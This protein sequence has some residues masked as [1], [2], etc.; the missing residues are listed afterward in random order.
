MKQISTALTGL[1]C[2][3][4]SGAV[5]AQKKVDT[6]PVKDSAK[7]DAINMPSVLS[8][9]FANL[10]YS[11]TEFDSNGGDLTADGFGLSGSYLLPANLVPMLP[12]LYV[13]AGYSM[14]ETEKFSGGTVEITDYRLGVGY[15]LALSNVL[16]L[17]AEVDFL[18]QEGEGKGSFSGIEGDDDGF[19]VGALGRYA[20]MPQVEVGGGVRYIDIGEDSETQFELN[21][22]YHFAQGFSA[23]VGLTNSS[24]ATSYGAGARYNFGF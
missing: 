23:F 13:T 4:F 15:R 9:T 3:A 20:V 21:G 22:L 5:M 16:D 7:A 2:V 12:S 24:E 8:Y 1:L 17:N 14:I 18:R 11:R 6:V 10:G 19:R